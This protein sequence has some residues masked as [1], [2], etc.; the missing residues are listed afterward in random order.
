[1]TVWS[2]LACLNIRK[3]LRLPTDNENT[4]ID[5]ENMPSHL[6]ARDENMM[7]MLFE[8][9]RNDIAKF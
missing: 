2:N 6:I 8:L 3:D 5:I 9:I 7:N 1:M 4:F